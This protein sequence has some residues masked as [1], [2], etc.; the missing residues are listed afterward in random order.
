MKIA[1]NSQPSAVSKKRPAAG[2]YLRNERRKASMSCGFGL[3]TEG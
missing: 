1:I 2:D 3:T